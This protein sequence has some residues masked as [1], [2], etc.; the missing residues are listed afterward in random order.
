VFISIGYIKSDLL[1]PDQFVSEVFSAVPSTALTRLQL[2]QP[3]KPQGHSR[4]DH[5]FVCLQDA[6][7]FAAVLALFYVLVNAWQQLA[8]LH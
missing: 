1:P 8:A 2:S 3:M 5:F 7:L 4:A 6:F